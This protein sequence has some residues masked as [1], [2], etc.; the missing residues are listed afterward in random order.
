MGDMHTIPHLPLPK[1]F[2]SAYN[3]L[4]C[5]SFSLSTEKNT[6]RDGKGINKVKLYK[7]KWGMKWRQCS[8]RM[9]IRSWSGAH[10]TVKGRLDLSSL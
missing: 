6:G 2:F 5:M 3:V 1:S 7:S 10:D 8:S 4:S 9:P